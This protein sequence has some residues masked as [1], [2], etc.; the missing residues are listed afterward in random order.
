[1]AGAAM[2][3]ASF[4]VL[5]AAVMG[6]ALASAC[7]GDDGA[8]GPAGPAGDVGPSGA[9][10]PSGPAGDV[11]PTGPA[12]PSGDAGADALR[13]APPLAACQVTVGPAPAYRGQDVDVSVVFERADHSDVSEPVDV[14]F[15][16]GTAT[17]VAPGASPG[18][19]RLH[20][21]AVVDSS[22]PSASP[23]T[24]ARSP[25]STSPSTSRQ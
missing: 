24:A 8:A 6:V 17:D 3:A 10:G 1:M 9:T 12:G 11:G 13:G 16:A 21:R 19:W 14:H 22:T 20:T 7:A 23:A 15:V 25:S 4:G 2:R 5:A 18:A